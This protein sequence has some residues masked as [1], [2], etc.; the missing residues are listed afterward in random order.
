MR[1]VKEIEIGADLQNLIE[2]LNE[3][4]EDKHVFAA[5]MV[6]LVEIFYLRGMRKSKG[7]QTAFQDFMAGIVDHFGDDYAKTLEICQLVSKC[8]NVATHFDYLDVKGIK[9]EIKGSPDD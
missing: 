8:M 5:G 2:I 6:V 3:G 7:A 4:I 1:V 9:R